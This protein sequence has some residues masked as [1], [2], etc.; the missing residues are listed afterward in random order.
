MNEDTTDLQHDAL[1]WEQQVPDEVL[2]GEIQDPAHRLRL[3]L[4]FTMIPRNEEA[5]VAYLVHHQ[6]PTPFIRAVLENN[7]L[8]AVR[9]GSREELADLP[10]LIIWIYRRAPMASWGTPERV[11]KWLQQQL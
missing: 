2:L 9:K 1:W 6:S 11:Q 4:P 7:L 5:L 3:E 8:D 10:E